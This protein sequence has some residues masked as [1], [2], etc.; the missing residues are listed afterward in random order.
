MNQVN[1]QGQGTYPILLGNMSEAMV[2]RILDLHTT[3]KIL[4]KT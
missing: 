4:V 1:A 2:G 3:V